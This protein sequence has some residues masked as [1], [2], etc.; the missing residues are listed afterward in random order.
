MSDAAN[1]DTQTEEG[2]QTEEKLRRSQLKR[3]ALQR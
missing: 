2:A 3:K 1:E